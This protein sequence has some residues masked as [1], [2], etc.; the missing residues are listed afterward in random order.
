MKSHSF[1]P[2][3]MLLAGTLTCLFVLLVQA[4]DKPEEGSKPAVHKGSDQPSPASLRKLLPAD[5][6]QWESFGG[7]TRLSQDGRWLAYSIRRVNRENEV[8]LRMLATD[9]KEIF[10]NASNP[11]FSADSQWLAFSIGLA[12]EEREKL[13]KEKKPIQNKLGLH[14]LVD[15]KTEEFEKVQSFS[16]SEDGKFLVMQMYPPKGRKSKG[17]DIMVRDLKAG[18]NT[19]FGNIASFKWNDELSLL[20]MI[21]D[22]EDQAGNGIQIYD[23]E[24]GK[25]TTLDSDQ[26]DYKSLSWR[27]DADDL[28]AF[29]ESKY[30]E[31]EDTTRQVLTWR[32]L[33]HKKPSHKAFDHLKHEDFPKGFRVV[34]FEGV[35]WSDDGK[36]VFFGIQEWESKPKK[37]T[38]EEEEPKS[39]EE[40]T[41]ESEVEG[42]TEETSPAK[43]ETETETEAEADSEADSE[44]ESE[45]ESEPRSES[46]KD[47]ETEKTPEESEDEDKKD[48]KKKKKEKSLKES[49][50]DPAGV[51]VWHAK[52]I[53]IIPRQKKTESQDRKKNFLAAWII[54]ENRLVQLGDELTEEVTLLEKQKLALGTDNTPYETEKRFGPTLVDAYIINTNSGKRWK[55]FDRTKYHFSSSPDGRYIPYILDDHFWL[56]D[57]KGKEASNLTKDLDS[58]FINNERNT[59]TD[60]AAPYGVGGWSKDGKQFFLYDRFDVWRFALDGSKAECLTRG[61]EDEIRYRRVSFDPDE[62][63]F[64]DLEKPMYLSMYSEK[65]KRSGYARMEWGELPETLVWKDKNIGSLIKA[66]EAD[67]YAYQEGDFADSPDAFVGNLDRRDMRQVSATNPFQA[68]FFWGRSELVD[69]TNDH[70]KALQGALFYPANYQAGKQYPMIVY[71]YETRSQTLHSYYT[72]SERSAYNTTVFSAEGYFV[73]Q[74]DI[75]YRAQNPGLS[76]KEC[77]I[78]AVKKVLESGMVD[79]ER[80]GLVGHSWGGYQTAFLSTQT[81]L[82]AAL[83]AGAP[84]TNMMSMSMSIYWNS[85]QTDAWIFHESQGRMDRPFWKD[86]DTYMANSAIFNIEN[87]NNPLLVA[88]GDEDGAVDWQQGIELYNAARLAQKPMVMLVYPGENHGLAKKPNQVDYHYRILEWFGHYLK[89]EEAPPWIIEGQSYLDRQKEVKAFKQKKKTGQGKKK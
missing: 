61:E 89:G 50:K 87:L 22:A 54:P 52:D 12:P 65:T 73:F 86:V 15:G 78:P 5:Y 55:A 80:V 43:P 63:R 58:S 79:P 67:V 9:A 26:A 39:E 8:R 3:H 71:I 24:K 27:K 29:K 1:R 11:S 59:L 34:D 77:V 47:A 19:G 60:Q 35:K 20:A 62:D 13:E 37:L 88:F 38:E 33:N 36:R 6:G 21:V 53:D 17:K 70:G 40:E 48:S 30:E 72:P 85:G 28:A 4:E 25:L 10:E 74:P 68:E 75:V 42:A 51:E 45:S 82:F 66:K 64:I 49:L 46:S 32:R 57:C 56:Y 41:P 81:D 14:S 7:R 18:L 83:V 23:P 69:Y 44:A 76:A 2:L 31:D 16:F 84:L